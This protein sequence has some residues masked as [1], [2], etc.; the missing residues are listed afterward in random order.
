MKRILKA[1]ALPVAGFLRPFL[2]QRILK[3]FLFR[4]WAFV[5]FPD[6]QLTLSGWPT[7][8]KLENIEIGRGCSINQ[9]VL[10]QGR[11]KIILGNYVTLSPYVMLLDGGL[12]TKDIVNGIQGKQHYSARIIIEDHV[13]IG[14]GAII[15]SGV[16]IGARSI[17]AAGAVVTKDVPPGYLVAGV[18][19]KL[20]K[21][22]SLDD[23]SMMID[24]G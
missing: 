6:K 10:I 3:R 22:I 15:L 12:S 17:V 2:C 4:I 24:S 20:I 21:C 18:P 8:L 23:N 14:A 11:N 7:L 19:A 16:R 13:W 5:L 1:V 9:G